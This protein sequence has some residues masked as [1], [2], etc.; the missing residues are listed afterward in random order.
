MARGQNKGPGSF[1]VDD[2]QPDTGNSGEELRSDDANGSGGDSGSGSRGSL[3]GTDP[4]SILGSGSDSARDDDRIIRDADGNPTYSPTGRIRKRRSSSGS[5]KAAKKGEK[6]P[7]DDLAFL[8][9]MAHVGVANLT[10]TPE[11]EINEK[12]ANMLADPMADILAHYGV[13]PPPEVMMWSKMFAALSYVYPPR[14]Y[15]IRQRLISEREERHQRQSPEQ[16]PAE[17]NTDIGGV[18]MGDVLDFATITPG[19]MTP[20]A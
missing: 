7:I 1:D 18:F 20:D 6:V 10:R 16:T 5:G 8:L 17:T 19:K 3:N 11:A 12:E 9:R 15:M 4:G 14:V 2:E 13:K